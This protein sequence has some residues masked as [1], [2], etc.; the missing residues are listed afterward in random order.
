M[1]R[2]GWA[3]V[4]AALLRSATGA[5]VRSDAASAPG[6]GTVRLVAV[7]D[8]MPAR[9]MAERIDRHGADWLW[10]EVRPLLDDGD[11]RFGNL[12]TAVTTRGQPVG[13]PFPFRVP[14]ARARQVLAAGGF[15]LV[16]LAN[17]HS[18]DYG[19]IGLLDAARSLAD[20]AAGVGLSRAEAVAPRVIERYGLRVGLVAYTLYPGAAEPEDPLAVVRD[21]TF[22]AEIAAAAE[23]V[24]TLVVSIHWGGEYQPTPTIRQVRLARL[25]IESGAAAVLGHGPH[26]R[27]PLDSWQGK[28]IVYSLGNA[29]FDRDTPRF[30]NGWLVRLALRPGG[31]EVEA[32]VKLKLVEG[33]PVPEEEAAAEGASPGEGDGRMD[34]P[35]LQ[36]VILNR[37]ERDWLGIPGIER[38]P[39]GVLWA[40]AYT[41]GPKEPDPANKVLVWTSTDDGRTWSVPEIAADPEGATRAFDPTLWLDPRG[42]LHLIHNRGNIET[43]THGIWAAV[44]DHPDDPNSRFG[45]ARQVELDVPM[46]YR[47][48]KPIATSWGEWVMPV[49]W[50]ESQL[51]R[52]LPHGPEKQGVA[53]SSDEG[54]TWRLRGAVEAPTWA[55]ENMIVERR[56]GSLWMLI[57]AGGGRIW[58]SVSTDRGETWSEGR[59]TAIDNP[60]SRFYIGRLRS[61]N[62][63]L[64]N[65]PLPAGRTGLVAQLSADDGATWGEPLM[66]DPRERVS[67][68][69]A[70]QGADGTVYA[71]HDRDRGGAGEVL[72]SVFDEG[73][74]PMPPAT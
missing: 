11:I 21:E 33:R 49:T 16:S 13:Q 73:H 8:I 20:C 53:I 24:D 74:L 60:G 9:G 67:Y 69:D 34:E 44:N 51:E 61:G 54:R 37:G 39:G 10:D 70:C 64:I 25:A 48:N 26:V 28:P 1:S 22:A 36:Q 56:D 14:P 46:C 5:G 30:S 12:E 18:A 71:V 72:L 35:R 63:L 2:L 7:G 41:G 55:L 29:V 52:W 17:N 15:G 47:M 42:R 23:G 38:S 62:L 57:R 4:L 32:A 58:E 3:L 66:L 59:A 68:P 19:R 43:G 50:A 31:A 6:A 65:S 27:Q 40:T 45:E